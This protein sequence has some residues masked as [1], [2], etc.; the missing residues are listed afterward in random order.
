MI[1]KCVCCCEILRIGFGCRRR[2][3]GYDEWFYDVGRR[4]VFL[5]YFWDFVGLF[6]SFGVVCGGCLIVR[7]V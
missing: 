5:R 2:G 6:F 1:V 7:V 4:V 3:A